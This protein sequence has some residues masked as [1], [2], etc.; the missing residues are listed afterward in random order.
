[1]QHLFLASVFTFFFVLPLHAQTAA[2]SVKEAVETAKEAVEAVTTP[3]AEAP[4][5]ATTPTVDEPTTPT[6]PT[7]TEPKAPAA[8]VTPK[9]DAPKNSAKPEANKEEKTDDKVETLNLLEKPNKEHFEKA[10]PQQVTSECGFEAYVGLRVLGEDETPMAGSKKIDPAKL[11]KG[12]RI[13]DA[14]E[15]PPDKNNPERLNLIID[16]RRVVGAAFC[17]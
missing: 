9:S 10:Q 14:N 1:M 6:A 12:S 3:A 8:P 2:P 7:V 17:G 16:H 5:A 15:V 11:P 4:K 13:F